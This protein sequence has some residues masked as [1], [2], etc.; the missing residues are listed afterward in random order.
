MQIDQ[1]RRDQDEIASFGATHAAISAYLCSSWNLGRSVVEAVGLHHSPGEQDSADGLTIATAVHV[2]R[3]LVD[4]GMDVE[5]API[6]FDHLEALD[7]AHRVPVWVE[8]ATEG[9][10]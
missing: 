2:A 4:A 1:S 9:A 3:G 6:D 7:L 10:H 5:T 8:L